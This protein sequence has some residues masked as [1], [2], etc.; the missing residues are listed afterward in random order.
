MDWD[1]RSVDLENS[2]RVYQPL[3]P[4]PYIR[5]LHL[6]PG[7]ESEPVR[8]STEIVSLEEDST[9]YDAISCEW[10][11]AQD[12]HTILMDNCEIQI[13]NNLHSHLKAL[14]DDN[15]V[16]TVWVDAL[17][18]DQTSSTE[19]TIRSSRCGMCIAR[20]KQLMSFWTPSL[21]GLNGKN[22]MIRKFKPL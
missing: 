11:Q 3:P 6:R 9:K 15:Q 16:F 7:K 22:G 13:R 12:M 17:Y 1:L 5:I 20:P 21:V 10:G 8:C 4:G 14:R 2:K 19:K 18:I